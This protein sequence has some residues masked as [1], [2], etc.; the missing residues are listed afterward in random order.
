MRTNPKKSKGNLG[1]SYEKS[2]APTPI[3][4]IATPLRKNKK[5][6]IVCAQHLYEQ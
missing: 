2:I 5:L 6:G 3:I 4:A 1:Y